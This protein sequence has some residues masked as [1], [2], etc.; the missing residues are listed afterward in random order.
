MPGHTAHSPSIQAVTPA[1]ACSPCPPPAPSSAVLIVRG[2]R[3][4]AQMI[5]SDRTPPPMQPVQ[6][7]TPEQAEMQAAQARVGAWVSEG[8]V[9]DLLQATP[10]S[11]LRPCSEPRTR[12]G[13]PERWQQR[14]APCIACPARTLAPRRCR[15]EPAAG[16]S[17]SVRPPRPCFHGRG[18][19]AVSEQRAYSR[20][21]GRGKGRG[22]GGGGPPR[23]P[24]PPSG[25]V[26]SE[27]RAPPP[28][29]V[30]SG[31]TVSLTPY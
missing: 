24:R 19:H 31:H 11:V 14:R 17:G 13:R 29:L 25:I 1:P 27:E 16:A 4:R 7:L 12:S 26:C 2:T 3:A 30:L 10:S 23:P 5:L 8:S 21:S 28:P 18:S 15:S 6:Y 9:Y 20:A 22:G